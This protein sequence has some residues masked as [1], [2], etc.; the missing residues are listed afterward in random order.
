MHILRDIV[1]LPS[2]GRGECEVWYQGINATRE[3]RMASGV[4]V[5]NEGVWFD[6]VALES[7]FLLISGL[8]SSPDIS[9]RNAR[10]T[11]TAYYLPPPPPYP[12]PHKRHPSVL[13]CPHHSFTIHPQLHTPLAS[14]CT[15]AAA[16]EQPVTTPTSTHTIPTLPFWMA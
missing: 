12:S 11:N 1:R 14:P 13:P 6:D 8:S 5:C 7:R 10:M 2:Q 15:F 4:F 3:S 16:A 9:S